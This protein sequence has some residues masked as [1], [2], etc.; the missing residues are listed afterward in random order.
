MSL[1]Y[2]SWP[3]CRLSSITLGQVATND[4]CLMC[5]ILPCTVS[6]IAS[7]PAC[8]P[9]CQV[10]SDKT[11]IAALALDQACREMDCHEH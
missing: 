5:L 1:P 10:L 2:V 11:I 8:L 6:R 7:D 9:P 3:S 4:V